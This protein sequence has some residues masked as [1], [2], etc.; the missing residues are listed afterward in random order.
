MRSL[1]G[2]CIR[3]TIDECRNTDVF[4]GIE[5]GQQVM[6]LKNKAEVL[7]AKIGQFFLIQLRYFFAGNKNLAT[8]GSVEGTQNMEQGAFPCT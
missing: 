3:S 4:Q 2:D 1:F 7:A 6:K 8:I 5:L